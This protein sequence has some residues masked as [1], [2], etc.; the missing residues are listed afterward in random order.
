M[1]TDAHRLDD[2]RKV[3]DL[4]DVE[5]EHKLRLIRTVTGPTY[6]PTDRCGVC[7]HE[8]QIHDKYGPGEQCN[9][10]QNPK[11]P[12]AMACKC[13]KFV[14]P[15]DRAPV[16]TVIPEERLPHWSEDVT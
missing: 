6:A 4:P 7:G 11:I 12:D 16:S 10:V 15:R 3:L 9:W 8:Y 1:R 14:H 5:D 2:I 13:G